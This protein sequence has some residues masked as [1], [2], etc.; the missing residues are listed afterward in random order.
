[1]I[2]AHAVSGPIELQEAAIDS[3][4]KWEFRPFLVMGEPV[5]FESKFEVFFA[6]AR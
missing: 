6:L 4:R 2:E 5:E 1:M 3:V